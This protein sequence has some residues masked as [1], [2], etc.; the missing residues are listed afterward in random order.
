MD[1]KEIDYMR[2]V[3][4]KDNELNKAKLVKKDSKIHYQHLYKDYKTEVNC[5]DL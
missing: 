1:A 3:V 2:D 4:M 5:A